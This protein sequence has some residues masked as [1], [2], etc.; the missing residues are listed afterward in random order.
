MSDRP[1]LTMA[2]RLSWHGV[3]YNFGDSLHEFVRC[4]RGRASQDCR[5]A[6]HQ[7]STFFEW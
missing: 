3:I 4:L 2:T 1:N 6:L 5:P 7:R